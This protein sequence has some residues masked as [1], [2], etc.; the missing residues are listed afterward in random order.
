MYSLRSL[1]HML[2]LDRLRWLR[3]VLHT[4]PDRI[5]LY[6]LYSEASNGWRLGQGFQ[7]MTWRTSLNSLSRRWNRRDFQVR[8]FKTFVIW[9]N[10]AVIAHVFKMFPPR[11][12]SSESRFY[13]IFSAINRSRDTA[14]TAGTRRL[15]IGSCKTGVN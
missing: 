10:E 6:A 3:H 11:Q 13:D 9:I 8:R 7:S 12:S 15:K 5:L 2:T 4:S 1:E 14:T